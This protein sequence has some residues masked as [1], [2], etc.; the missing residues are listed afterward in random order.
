M[1]QLQRL[2]KRRSSPI[3]GADI[4]RN[5]RRSGGMG[6][7]T[8]RG[9]AESGRAFRKACYTASAVGEK[10]I[11]IQNNKPKPDGRMLFLISC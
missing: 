3:L 10:A 8:A 2:N 7:G 11:S 5:G 9:G 6:N 4:Q 1:T